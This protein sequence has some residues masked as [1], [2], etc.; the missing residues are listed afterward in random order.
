M[1]GAGRRELLQPDD[2]IVEELRDDPPGD[3]LDR[4]A[5]VGGELRQIDARNGVRIAMLG[6]NNTLYIAS[7]CNFLAAVAVRRRKP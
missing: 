6:L 5:L 7:F 3:G 4:L 2:R 1:A